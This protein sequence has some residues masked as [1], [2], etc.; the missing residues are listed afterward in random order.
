MADELNGKT[1]M[2]HW[3][4]GGAALIWNLFG[5]MIYLTQVKA[6]PEQLAQQYN[7]AEIAF[8]NSI[9]VWATSANAI[10]VT[11][12]V[13]GSVLL[14]LRNSMALLFFVVSLGALLVQD[15]YSFA[16]VDVVAV[17]GMLPVYIQGTV[18]AVAIVLI[19]YARAARNRGLLS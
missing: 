3:L 5:F 4:V 9:P 7:V 16:L 11:A 17:F 15:L 6:T 14:L 13:L 19:F 1:P 12:G 10:A 8:L 18:L 2:M